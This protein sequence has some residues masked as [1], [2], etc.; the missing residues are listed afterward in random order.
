MRMWSGLCG[1][2][3]SEQ[4]MLGHM[5]MSCVTQTAAGRGPPGAARVKI[6]LSVLEIVLGY[7][8]LAS[9][10]D[11]LRQRRSGSMNRSV[12]QYEQAGREMRA[13]LGRRFR[14][15]ELIPGLF[16]LIV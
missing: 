6:K 4:G 5:M 10:P 7:L 1:G 13:V 12:I 9:P 2:S 14:K 8:R 16:W 11:G 15:K 3:G